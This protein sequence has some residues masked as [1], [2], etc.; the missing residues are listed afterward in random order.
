VLPD[1]G[2]V[3][4]VGEGEEVPVAES[5]PEAAPL[6]ARREVAAPAQP[7][8]LPPG[9]VQLVA[10]V[11]DGDGRALEGLRVE[12]HGALPQG[13]EVELYLGQDSDSWGFEPVESASEATG[14]TDWDGTVVFEAA[15]PLAGKHLVLGRGALTR[16][17]AHPVDP[18]ADE[19]LVVID[20]DGEG[21][22]GVELDLME[23][24]GEPLLIDEVRARLVRLLAE[25]KRGFA[26]PEPPPSWRTLREHRMTS[27]GSSAKIGGL[28]PGH[29]V[30]CVTAIG[31]GVA[32][33]EVD[34]VADRW[35]KVEARL[36]L[37]E[38]WTT[39]GATL[40]AEHP[41]LEPDEANGLADYAIEGQRPRE[42]GKGGRDGYLRHTFR[43]VPGP[44][45]ALLELELEAA[46]WAGNDAVHLE[47]LG[48]DANPR[49]AWGARIQDL[50]GA[51]ASWTAGNYAFIQLDLSELP[52]PEGKPVNLL[53]SLADGKLDLLVQDDTIV[54][55]ARLRTR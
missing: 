26:D 11:R 20:L 44:E 32:R 23:P 31:G 13:G 17:V 49:W 2:R 50:P 39:G 18:E 25:Q 10:V 43:F 55:S 38:F 19:Q 24:G 3:E 52:G 27:L 5:S 40:D 47:F 15:E 6:G 8:E 33:I 35:A 9:I 42:L 48:M 4:P 30:L 21:T 29:W 14:T 41:V 54:H 16:L 36:P 53:P 37:R 28:A 1:P 12:L 22:G 34:V 7:E 46:G 51:P 45:G